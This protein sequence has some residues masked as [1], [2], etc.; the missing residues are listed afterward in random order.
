MPGEPQGDDWVG[1][2][3]SEPHSVWLPKPVQPMLY[4]YLDGPRPLVDRVM[5]LICKQLGVERTT[6]HDLRRTFCSTVT[7]LGFGRD[8]MDRIA[9]HKS[10]LVRDVYD[11]HAYRNED[12]KIMEAVSAHIMAQVTGKP[13]ANN[14]IPLR[15]P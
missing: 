12:R 14:V 13:E 4:A 15:Q 11:R 8:A 2:K 1:T 3:N 6:P 9:N 7:A 5:R 10:N